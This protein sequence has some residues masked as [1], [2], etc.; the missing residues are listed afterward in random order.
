[1]IV[2]AVGADAGIVRFDGLD[3][4]NW[5]AAR[6]AAGIGY[7]PQSVQLLS[8]SVGENIRRLG[9][10]DDE[11][12]IAA[13]V[14]AGA[15]G[16]ITTLPQGYETQIGEGGISL[17]GGQRALIGL[18]RALY[19]GP[20]IIVLD[21]PTAHLDGDGR[22]ALGEALGQIRRAK[23]TL[24]MVS[25]DMTA[26]RAFDLLVAMRGGR[27]EA[28]GPPDKLLVKADAVPGGNKNTGAS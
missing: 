9:E 2:G 26:L 17:S 10:R 25:H 16:M 27:I 21:E 19:G 22:K 28:A 5:P 24:I 4:R 12:V 14:L 11:A 3:I 7:L 13:A 15:H 6:L 23:K 8:G 20:D 18:A 1:V